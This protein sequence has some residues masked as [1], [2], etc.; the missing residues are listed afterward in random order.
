MNEQ[1]DGIIEFGFSFEGVKRGVPEMISLV[2]NAVASVSA[3]MARLN[4]TNASGMGSGLM[5]MAGGVQTISMGLSAAEGHAGRLLTSL[6]R[7]SGLLTNQ[8][9]IG[10]TIGGFALLERTFTTALNKAREFQTAQI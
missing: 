6:D 1:N 9:G 4:A 2:D 3:S 10:A 7:M 8:L 5:G